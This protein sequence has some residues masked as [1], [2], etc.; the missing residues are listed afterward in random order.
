M[1]EINVPGDTGEEGR[2]L[3]VIPVSHQEYSR[4]RSKPWGGPNKRQ[5][6]RVGGKILAT[7]TSTSGGSTVNTTSLSGIH[8]VLPSNIVSTSEGKTVTV[9][10]YFKYVKK[11]SPII[12]CDLT[13]DLAIDNQTKAT[14]SALPE[15]LHYTI[16]ERAVRLAL[17]SKADK[18][19]VAR[20]MEEAAARQRQ[21]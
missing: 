1:E 9:N 17:T 4:L 12:L 14:T 13:E 16:L 7:T 19:Q 21:Q 15:S 20:N 5:A 18:L 2:Y 6:W 8:L 3:E 11:P 10:Y